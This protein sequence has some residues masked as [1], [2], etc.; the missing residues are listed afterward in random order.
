M[1]T[2]GCECYLMMEIVDSFRNQNQISDQVSCKRKYTIKLDW[3]IARYTIS[4]PRLREIGAKPKLRLV[5]EPFYEPI[6]NQ[7]WVQLSVPFDLEKLQAKQKQ[8][9]KGFLK[10]QIAIKIVFC[11]PKWL[12]RQQIGKWKP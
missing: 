6:S 10:R 8:K 3:D 7:L 9:E 1:G 11:C 5:E 12:S 2:F 4:W